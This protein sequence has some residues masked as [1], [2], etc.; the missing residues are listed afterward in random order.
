MTR[1]EAINFGNLWLDFNEKYRDSVTVQFFRLAV[2]ALKEQETVT[3]FADRCRECGARYGR[4]LRSLD[5]TREEIEKQEKWL[6]QAGY[7]A[8]NVDIAFD[9]I[10]HV[11]AESEG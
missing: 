9:A 3:E 6:L 4:K 8:Y 10:K 11:I 1:E 5:K 2:K 7:S